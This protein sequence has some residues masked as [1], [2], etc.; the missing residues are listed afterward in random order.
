MVLTEDPSIVKRDFITQNM[1]AFLTVV[2]MPSYND[3]KGDV[4][5]LNAQSNITDEITV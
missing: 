4:I 2:P 3:D 5:I 1:D